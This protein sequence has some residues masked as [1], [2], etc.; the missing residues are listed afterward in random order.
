[1]TAGRATRYPPLLHS[2]RPSC[3]TSCESFA[4]KWRGASSR[5]AWSATAGAGT[6][7]RD[8][9]V[10]AI[11]LAHRGRLL[12]YARGL[13]GDRQHADAAVQQ[14]SLRLSPPACRRPVLAPLLQPLR[15][16]PNPSFGS[17]AARRAGDE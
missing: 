3:S 11:Y 16:V 8:R 1:M 14:A 7:A 6:V 4:A 15:F 10:P 17:A 13:L 12:D 2:V 9:S 5:P